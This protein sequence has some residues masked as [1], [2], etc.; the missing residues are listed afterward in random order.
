MTKEMVLENLV[1]LVGQKFDADEVI[2]AFGDFEE[3]G[4]TE[5]IIEDSYLTGIDKIAYINDEQASEFCFSL[6]EEEEIEFV[7][8]AC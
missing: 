2:Y 6:N 1:K 4:K 7:W 5:V 8:V 3:Y